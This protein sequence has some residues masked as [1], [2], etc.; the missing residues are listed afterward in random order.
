LGKNRPAFQGTRLTIGCKGFRSLGANE[1]VLSSSKAFVLS[2]TC[3]NQP[4][5]EERRKRTCT[6]SDPR[7]DDASTKSMSSTTTPIFKTHVASAQDI[8][9][10]VHQKIAYEDFK[11]LPA[12]DSF[13]SDLNF[14]SQ[15]ACDIL[16][17]EELNELHA[18][19]LFFKEINI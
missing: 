8:N 2:Q 10:E 11:T 9:S 15:T 1:K 19:D 18:F 3:A 13:S 14:H 12:V 17:F 4:S 5:S 16:D 6:E 7:L